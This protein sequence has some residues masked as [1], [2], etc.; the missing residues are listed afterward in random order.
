MRKNNHSYVVFYIDNYRCIVYP[1]GITSCVL[2]LDECE[3]GINID[4]TGEVLCYKAMK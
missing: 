2:I 4:N 1:T 3:Y